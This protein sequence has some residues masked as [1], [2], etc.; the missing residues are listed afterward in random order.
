LTQSLYD[1]VGAYTLLPKETN[2]AMKLDVGVSGYWENS[3][4]L[5]YFGKYITQ[6][7]GELKV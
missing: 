4:P 6:T 7:N 1:Y 3:I 2:T 5:S